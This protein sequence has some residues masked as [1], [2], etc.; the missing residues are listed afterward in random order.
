[1]CIHSFSGQF[2]TMACNDAAICSWPRRLMPNAVA[3]RPTPMH[4]DLIVAVDLSRRVAQA[5]GGHVMLAVSL[6]DIELDRQGRLSPQ[7]NDDRPW[8]LVMRLR[9]EIRAM[10]W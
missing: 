1:M 5:I 4:C 9:P 2:R 10:N 3:S 7:V 8:L 6:I